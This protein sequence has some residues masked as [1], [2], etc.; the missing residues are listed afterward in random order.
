MTFEI[1]V[2]ETALLINTL[3]AALPNFDLITHVWIMRGYKKYFL[4]N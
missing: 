2:T 3:A 1:N 4:Y